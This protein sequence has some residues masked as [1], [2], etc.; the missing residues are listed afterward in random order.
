MRERLEKFALS[1]HPEKTRLT[2]FDRY[3]ANRRARRGL[4]KPESF[5]FLG[6]AFICGESRRGTFQ[7][8]R[9]TRRDRM[10]VKVRGIEQE[11]RLRMH[12]PIPSQGKWLQQIVSGYSITTPCRRTVAR[13]TCSATLSLNSGSARC[14]DAARS[15][16]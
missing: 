2:E 11:M 4:G 7:L 5:S 10:R 1:L 12:Q 3:A 14:G 15:T 8:K 13:F 6:F 16:A 9:K